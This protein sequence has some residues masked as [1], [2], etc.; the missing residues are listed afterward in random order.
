MAVVAAILLLA[1]ATYTFERDVSLWLAYTLPVV[2]NSVMCFGFARTLRPGAT[3]LITRVATRIRGDLPPEVVRYSRGVT[4]AWTGFFAFCAIE[5]LA[6][7]L[8]APLEVWSLFA[9]VINY[10]LAALLFI[11]E[12]GLR[13]RLLANIEHP[14]FLS[15]VRSLWRSGLRDSAPSSRA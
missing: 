11:V 7:A 14:S 12:Y 9:N 2:I 8:F 1:F 6:L 13:R 4:W 5:T 15:F 3:P 10:V